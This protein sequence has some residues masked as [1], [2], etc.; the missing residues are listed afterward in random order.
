MCPTMVRKCAVTMVAIDYPHLKGQL[1]TLMGPF[2][3][4]SQQ[5][6]Q[7]GHQGQR[8]KAYCR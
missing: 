1:A 2:T 3:D 4:H 8:S 5:M 7:H 6:V